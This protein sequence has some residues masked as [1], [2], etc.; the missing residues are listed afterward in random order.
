MEDLLRTSKAV[1]GLQ[2]QDGYLYRNISDARSFDG[3]PRVVYSPSTERRGQKADYGFPIDP[4]HRLC[5]G[6]S[7]LRDEGPS[8]WA[9]ITERAAF[10]L[11]E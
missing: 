11:G 10:D 4:S 2:T 7:L 6:D 8:R 9:R 3:K 1:S 5:L